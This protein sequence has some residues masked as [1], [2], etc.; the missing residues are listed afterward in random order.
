MMWNKWCRKLIDME[1]L[2]I[3]MLLGLDILRHITPVRNNS[4]VVHL[5]TLDSP[6]LDEYIIS[7]IERIDNY[8]Y[9][10]FGFTNSTLTEEFTIFDLATREAPES[11]PSIKF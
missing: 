1:P 11:R 8:S 9:F 3:Y 6:S 5:H 10:F 4:K 7:Y 2:H